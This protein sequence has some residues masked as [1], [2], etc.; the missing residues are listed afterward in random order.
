MDPGERLSMFTS[1][2]RLR[3][4]PF[5][6]SPD[7]GHYY[8]A[9]AHEAAIDRLARALDDGEGMLLLTGGPGT[10]KT[11]LA[12]KLLERLGPEVETALVTNGH[13]ASRSGLIQA[14]LYDLGQPYH[15]RSEQ[16]LRLAL[17][18]HL[19]QT[20]QAG[21]RTVLVIDEAHHLSA[22]LL[23][24]L[25]QLGNLEARGCQAVQ[26]VLVGQPPLAEA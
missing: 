22:D 11:L 4:R 7:G 9:T 19:L 18:D 15:G 23:E 5:R 6:P 8:P 24:E 14:I 10:G 2:F 17:T 3:Q 16:E 21:K 26:V 13:L 25:R 12:Q 20:Y 1:H